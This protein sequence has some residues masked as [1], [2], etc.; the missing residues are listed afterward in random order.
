MKA[1]KFWVRRPGLYAT[2][3]V[4]VLLVVETTDI[5]FAVDSIPAV[6]AITLNAFIV[7]TSNVFA[8]L[9]LRSMYFAVAGMM[10]LFEY[11]HYGLSLV[12]MLIGAKML[13]VALLHGANG[14][15]PRHGCRSYRDLGG[16]LGAVAEKE[17][18]AS[19]PREGV[20]L[21]TL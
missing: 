19:L 2:P 16:G 20:P 21:P 10:D 1:N 17:E 3:L 7:Y 14:G 12:L 18:R 6:L 5:V 9:G 8:I 15:G 13:A 11:L 4:V